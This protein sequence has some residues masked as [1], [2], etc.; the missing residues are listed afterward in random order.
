MDI[1]KQVSNGRTTSALIAGVVTIGIVG[2]GY[3]FYK[4]RGKI[5]VVVPA[6][7]VKDV[8][9][10]DI[11]T[12]DVEEV[13]MA[14]TEE[15]VVI[16]I[17]TNNDDW[18]YEAELQTRKFDEPYIIHVDEYVGDEMGF[19]QETLTYYEGDDIMADIMDTPVYNWPMVTGPLRWGHGSKDSNVVYVRNEKLKKEYEVLR[20]HGSFEVEVTGLEE[21]ELRHS[22]LKFRDH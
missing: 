9:V 7:A 3:Y 6:E 12:D 10:D 11:H 18:D 1:E 14:D 5:E 16:N 19:K 17:F 15:A 8:S 22:V 4:K 20:H 13:E 21:A 2:I